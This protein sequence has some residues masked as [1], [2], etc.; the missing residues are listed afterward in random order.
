MWTCFFLWLCFAAA[1]ALHVKQVHVAS[2]SMSTQLQCQK[3]SKSSE[4]PQLRLRID[5]R[6]F[7]AYNLLAAGLALGANFLGCTSALMSVNPEP[8]R[9]AGFDRLYSIGGFSRCVDDRGGFEYI[10]PSEWTVDDQLLYRQLREAETP[11]YI[12]NKRKSAGSYG[13]I[14]A[15]Y[16]PRNRKLENI[17]VIKS[18]IQAPF[19]LRETLGDPQVAAKRLLDTSIAAPGSGKSYELLSAREERRGD[20]LYYIFEYTISKPSTQLYQHSISVVTSKRDDELITFTA[21]QPQQIFD[22]DGGVILNKAAAS[23]ELL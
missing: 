3:G 7:V 19:S 2:A 6:R 17:S 21:Q 20:A 13:T 1:A 18:P 8:F 4:N 12:R 14:S 11:E 9:A 23:F 16:S 15:F 5:P 10:Y 22:S